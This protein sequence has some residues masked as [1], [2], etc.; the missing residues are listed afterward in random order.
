MQLSA[1]ACSNLQAEVERFITARAQEEATG[2]KR[3]QENCEPQAG[4][5]KKARTSAPAS[6]EPGVFVLSQDGLQRC[7][8]KEFKGQKYVDVRMYW[9]V[10]LPLL[11][12]LL[13][14]S[15]FKQLW[16]ECVTSTFT[17]CFAC[18]ITDA[19]VFVIL[20]RI[21]ETCSC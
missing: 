8:V 11:L 5:L 7:V 17:M 13:S 14:F 2:R 20:I 15:C 12:F 4:K 21:L 18:S 3:E 10:S 1:S 16:Q 6:T 19:S 9:K